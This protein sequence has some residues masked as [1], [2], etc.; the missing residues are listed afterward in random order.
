MKR[1]A[2]KNMRTNET[3][4]R[5]SGQCDELASCSGRTQ[6]GRQRLEA[7]LLHH[8]V[9]TFNAAYAAA[10]DEQ[11]LTDWVEMFTDDA[12]YVVISRENADRGMPVGLIYCENKGMIFDRA[13]AMEKTAMF[14]PR[15][16]RH[17][18]GNLQILGEDDNGDI[19]ARANYVVVQ[20]L[21][22]RPDAKLH[23]VGVYYDRFRRVGA[24]SSWPSA[25]AST[26]TCWWTT[27]CASRCGMASAPLR[28]GAG[29]AGRR[30][31]RPPARPARDHPPHARTHRGAPAGPQRLRHRRRGR[32]D[33][34]RQRAGARGRRDQRSGPLAGVPVSVKDILDVAGLP[35]RW[36]SPL[37]ADAKPAVADIAAVVRLRAAGA[38]IVGK[39]TTSEFAHSPLGVSPLTG[40]TRNPWAPDLTCGGSSA[41]AGV[42][43]AAG[44]T[45]IAL[46]TDAGCSTRLPAA[47]TGVYGLKPT[48]GRI[49]H[50]RVPEAFA[51]FIH[52]GLIAA[53]VRDLA[54]ALDVVA[55]PQ[56]NDPHS[57]F[58]DAPNAVAGLDAP[59]LDGAHILL[60]LAD[61]Q[62][63]RRRGGRGR[64]PQ[65]GGGAAVARRHR[66]RGALSARPSR[67]RSGAPCSSRTGPRG[68]PPRR[69]SSARSCRRR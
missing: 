52:L 25:A 36:G 43:V 49:A 11:R 5:L 65:G 27:R 63:P 34:A 58:Q 53:H 7:L 15:Y 31:S 26:T 19:R 48:L 42:A 57:W 14:A 44:L 55:G 56:R 68:L 62:R 9:E 37:I 29:H 20:V 23:Q 41:G 4:M 51:N 33:Q 69:P 61:R 67:I 16:L 45:P 1:F 13:F 35:T 54:L 2:D 64:H 17:I 47:C 38:V 66:V 21:F 39:T 40:V 60:W 10:L 32:R 24:S 30:S 8:E 18:I 3:T 50:D 46:A 28:E 22:D 12:F 6:R 59:V